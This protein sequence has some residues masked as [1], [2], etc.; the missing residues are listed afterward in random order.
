MANTAFLTSIP[1]STTMCRDDGM[2]KGSLVALLMLIAVEATKE[3][4]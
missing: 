2:C 3:A 4:W 1:C